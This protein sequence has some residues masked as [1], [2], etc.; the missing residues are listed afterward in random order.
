MK[1]TTID[2]EYAMSLLHYEPTTGRLSW[3]VRK[4]QRIHVGDVAGRPNNTGY[5]QVRIDGVTHCVHRLAWLFVHGE[6]PPYD[7]DHID[8]DRSNNRIANLRLATRSENL[9]N[10]LLKCTNRSGFKCVH[11]HKAWGRWLAVIQTKGVKTVLGAFEDPAE[12]SRAY[13][14]AAARVHRYNPSAGEV[15]R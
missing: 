5:L 13:C 10:T 9:E 3:K 2:R 6:L 4:A 1:K 12:A 7:L 15:P 11:W 14:I 8:S